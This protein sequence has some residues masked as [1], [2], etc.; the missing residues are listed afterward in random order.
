MTGLKF[1]WD[2]AKNAANQKKHGVSFD[3]AATVFFRRTGSCTNEIND[4]QKLSA[5]EPTSGKARERRNSRSLSS[6]RNA[7]GGWL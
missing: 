6:E 1:E 3:E 2:E 4:Q 5:S 7:A